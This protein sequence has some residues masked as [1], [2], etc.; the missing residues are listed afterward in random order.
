MS[1][2]RSESLYDAKKGVRWYKSVDDP[3]HGLDLIDSFLGID[4]HITMNIGI[5]MY[6]TV[7]MIFFIHK[8]LRPLIDLH[9]FKL[10]RFIIKFG[11][12]GYLNLLW[13]GAKG[14]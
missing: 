5:E 7:I 1:I 11:F 12:G 6:V 14:E 3:L 9:V 8:R 10:F 4:I 2:D 13:I